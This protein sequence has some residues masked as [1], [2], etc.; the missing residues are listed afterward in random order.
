[1]MRAAA[2]FH[3]N[4]TRREIRKERRHPIATELLAKD[5]LAPGIHGVH[6]KYVLRQIY[7]NRLNLH[8]ADSYCARSEENPHYGTSMPL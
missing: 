5:N 1:M 2:R 7:A 4:Q 3:T 8:F 6:L